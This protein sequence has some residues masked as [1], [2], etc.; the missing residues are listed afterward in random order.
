MF[1][2][3]VCRLLETPS[4]ISL[5]LFVHL[6]PFS[7][8]SLEILIPNFTIINATKKRMLR[9]SHSSIIL[10]SLYFDHLPKNTSQLE[11]S[12]NS[13]RLSSHKQLFRRFRFIYLL[14]LGFG[15]FIFYRD[16]IHL[17]RNKIKPVLINVLRSLLVKCLVY[18][19]Q[20]GFCM[21][22]LT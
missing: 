8:R 11:Q 19:T 7:S 3:S 20:L 15:F 5:H 21:E 9:Q 13:L 18:G 4:S 2:S 1:Q 14:H 12:L 6:P 16:D 10:L 22:Q 17:F